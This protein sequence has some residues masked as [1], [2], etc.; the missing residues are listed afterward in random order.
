MEARA[1]GTPAEARQAP[2][3]APLSL[4]GPTGD[5]PP[6]HPPPGTPPRTAAPTEA[7]TEAPTPAPVGRCATL[8]TC[9]HRHGDP[10]PCAEET[11]ARALEDTAALETLRT[12]CPAVYSEGM[13]LGGHFW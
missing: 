4:A 10:M 8:G 6:G 2:R 1:T 13:A 9:A 11:P 5:D 3:P 7:P 12:L